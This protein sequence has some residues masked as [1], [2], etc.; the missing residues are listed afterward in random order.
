MSS[1]DTTFEGVYSRTRFVIN[2]KSTAAARIRCGERTMKMM[3]MINHHYAT[4]LLIVQTL[5]RVAPPAGLGGG[6]RRICTSP[7]ADLDL[8]VIRAT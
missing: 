2:G 6:G 5:N 1:T 8:K 7:P 3:M 4:Y